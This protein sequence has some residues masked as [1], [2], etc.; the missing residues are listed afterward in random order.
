M[1]ADQHGP[2]RQ[3][4]ARLDR[5]TAEHLLEVE[6]QG[7]EGEAL[8]GER[9]HGRQRGQREQR[10]RQQVRRQD[11]RRMA[12]LAPQQ[13]RET[14]D[15]RRG[16]QPQ[17]RWRRAMCRIAQQQD[18]EAERADVTQRGA[19]VEAVGAARRCRAGRG[20]PAGTPRRRSAR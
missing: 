2:G 6:G 15:G 10:P 3:Q 18:Q 9:A 13:Q 14:R 11:R 20:A 1:I 16:F 7:D 17:P 12:A 19:G 4:E 5:R 8:D